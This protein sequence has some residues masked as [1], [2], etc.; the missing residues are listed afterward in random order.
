MEAR[1]DFGKSSHLFRLMLKS[2]LPL[3]LTLV[4]AAAP[5]VA[6]DPPPA[7]SFL[8]KALEQ[9]D[10]AAT[11]ANLL[12]GILKA[13]EGRRSVPAPTEWEAVAAK[14]SQSAN[15]EVREQ[16]QALGAIFGSSSALR[17]M[18]KMLADPSADA[19]ARE[20]AMASLVAAKDPESLPLLLELAT[21]AG[22]LRRAALRG[23]AAFDDPRVAPAAVAAYPTLDT[24]EKREA[25]ATLLS[26]VAWAKGLTA[27]IDAGGIPVADLAAPQ[28]R[29]LK[30]FKDGQIEDWLRAHPALVMAASN[31]QAEIARYKEFLTP[32][33]VKSG[34][35]HRGRALFA[36]TC[37]LCHRLF[38]SGA[39][40]GPEIT[41][42]NRTD[43]DYLLQNIVDPN[44]LIGKDYQ[45][46]TI[47]T[48]DGRVLV[49]IVR[50]DDP[51][52]IALK[53]LAGAVVVPRGDVKSMTVSEISMMSEGLLAAFDREQVRD[54]FAYLGSP[55]Q[56]P[57]LATQLNATDFFNGRDLSRW[58]ASSDAWALAEGAIVCHGNAKKPESL[59]SSM[60]A[61]NFT[62]TAQI[63]VR[64]E[65]SAAEIVLRGDP[66]EE[67]FRGVSMSIG[68]AAPAFVWRYDL[69]GGPVPAKGSAAVPIDEWI[70]LE[71][72][73]GPERVKVRIAG[74][75]AF[76][77][78]APQNQ[79]RTVPA[80]YLLGEGAELAMK[81]LKIV[82]NQ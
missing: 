28:V 4:L 31:K 69:I 5:S 15:P 53:T 45:S 56:A 47:E 3:F 76:D 20:K 66:T 81:D 48:N 65:K 29:Q 30:G 25:I 80:F 68:A 8:M 44:A 19:S 63:K 57:M 51:N 60:I 71:I 17:A 7:L 27:A 59:A 67:T 14:L 37:A 2:L 64:G 10:D 62:L 21:P 42:A 40:I 74:R 34:D 49:G 23:L 6:D 11:Q 38:D 52:A 16:T 24:D 39:D 70:A 12:R 61:E 43:I 26:R 35:V 18:R 50:G 58:R 33:F 79:P 1:L 72:E 13:L 77:C 78:A 73:S 54:L 55:R 75:D 41:G 22:L 9:S 46:T 36:Q 82:V 32:E